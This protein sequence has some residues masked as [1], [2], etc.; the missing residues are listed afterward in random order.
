[1]TAADLPPADMQPGAPQGQQGHS[2]PHWLLLAKNV[3]EVKLLIQLRTRELSLG[4]ILPISGC[5]QRVLL[6]SCEAL[7]VTK[8]PR[9]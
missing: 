9:A 5:L 6:E 4:A 2:C 8:D 1:M 3:G 7:V